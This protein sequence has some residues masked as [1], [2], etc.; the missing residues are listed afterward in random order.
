[1]K[2]FLCRHGETAWS[3]SGQHTSYTDISLTQKGEAQAKSL[4]SKLQTIPWTAIYTSPLQRAKHTC[5]LAGFSSQMILEPKAVEWNYGDYEGLT[6]LEISKKNPS[7]NLFEN[8]APNGESLSEIRQ[9]TDLLIE[10]FLTQKGNILL[11][12][13][14]HF[15]RVFAARW[16]ELDVSCARLFGVSVAS[17]SILGFERKQRI[18]QMWNS[19]SDIP[20]PPQG[21]PLGLIQSSQD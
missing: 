19:G 6:S 9:R 4:K 5:S 13:H 21:H 1:M 11:F 8:G 14:G 10:Q 16:I 3:L 7:W 12:S 18:I 17:I 20:A 15:L 2:I